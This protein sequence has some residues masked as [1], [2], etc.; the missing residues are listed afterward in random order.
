MKKISRKDFLG[1]S[2][3]VLA[4]GS[5]LFAAACQSTEPERNNQAPAIGSKEVISWKMSTTWPS[6]FPVLGEG[7]NKFAELVHQMSG[8]RMRIDVYGDRELVPAFE[9]F[10]AVNVGAIEMGSGASYYWSGRVPEAQFFS[11]VPFGMNAQQMNSW[12]MSGG[13][14]QLWEDLYAQYD[15]VPFP[16]GNTGVQMGGW[17]NR[18]VNTLE[19]LQGLKMRIPGFGGKVISRAGVTAMAVPGSEVFTSLER[20]MIDATEWIGPY[21][22]Y[23]MG[24]HKIAKYYYYPGWHEPGTCLEL[25]ANKHL[26]DALPADLQQI[27]RTAAAWVNHWTLSELEAKN[28]EYLEKILQ[29]AEVELKIFPQEILTHLS[30]LTEEVIA[31]MVAE[32]ENAR[33]IY[34][35]YQAFQQKALQWANL[36]ER[37]YFNTLQPIA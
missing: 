21:H 22:D 29:E 35:S 5:T 7:A 18:E 3:A 19:D 24:F 14:M 26:F 31:E 16:G 33:K 9:L 36:T 34:A 17:F 30:R 12:L 37:A 2:A 10:D 4:G 6:N 20:G 28:A 32:N 15:L 8:G 25:I 11:A 27:I 1:K 23:L 13:G